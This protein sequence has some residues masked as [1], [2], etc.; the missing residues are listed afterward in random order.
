MIN[1]LIYSMWSFVQKSPEVNSG[2]QRVN[3]HYLILH[4][5]IYCIYY[6]FI[7]SEE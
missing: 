7:L 1:I 4:P 3:N 2:E 6:L 5:L